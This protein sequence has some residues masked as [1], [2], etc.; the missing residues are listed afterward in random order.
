MTIDLLSY[1]LLDYV[2]YF[3]LQNLFKTINMWTLL[4]F[5]SENFWAALA[6]IF[7]GLLVI[8]TIV[9]I[10]LQIRFS[11][12][13]MFIRNIIAYEEKFD[14]K[15]MIGY[16]KILAEQIINNS[17]HSQIKEPVMNFF[18]S[19]G[20][21]L[22]M[23]ALN[24]KMVWATFSFYSIRWWLSCQ[25]YIKDEQAANKHDKTI[26]NN[27]KYLVEIMQKM[28]A[29]EQKKTMKHKKLDS[30]DMIHFQLGEKEISEFLN[31]EKDEPFL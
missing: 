18:E 1:Y 16:R 14:S 31:N 10:A 19:L 2:I 29:K 22:R 28:E 20:L 26:F 8:A 7:A 5:H 25:Q 21:A 9:M 12:R 3:C 27:F 17:P 23:K 15:R 13:D 30:T 4:H 24:K 11:K 6:A